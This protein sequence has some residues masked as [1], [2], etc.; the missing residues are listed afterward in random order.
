MLTIIVGAV[1]GI[2]IYWTSVKRGIAPAEAQQQLTLTRPAFLSTES[3]MSAT[4]DEEAGMAIYLY[5]G[6]TLSLNAAK[7]AMGLVENATSNY[8]IGTLDSRMKSGLSGNDY[9]HCFVYTSGWI[10]VY[11][12]RINPSNPSTTGW[13]GKIIDW[14]LY[15]NNQLQGTYLSEG[16]NYMAGVLNVQV[17]ATN[18]HYHHFQYPSA[19]HMLFAVKQA[20]NDNTQT[21]NIEIPSSVTVSEYSWS[22]YSYG[23]GYTLKIDTTTISSGSGRNYGGPEITSTILS[24]DMFHTVSIICGYSG[25]GGNHAFVCLILVYF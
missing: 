6:T 20:G 9:P 12:L 13:V 7:N 8:V 25:L 16:L 11:Y 1:L 15:S 22:C 17:N 18:T 14:D 4:L 2:S 10:V 3:V 21:F 24:T 5:S 23:S 19:T